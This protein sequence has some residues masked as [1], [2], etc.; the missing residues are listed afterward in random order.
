M[1]LVS[2]GWG[3][4]RGTLG[5]LG[6][7]GSRCLGGSGSPFWVSDP[8]PIASPS[9]SCSDPPSQ[10][11]PRFHQGAGIVR[12][13]VRLSGK[14]GHIDRASFSG[15]LQSPVCH[16]QSHRGLAACHRPV[17]PQRLGGALQFSHEDCPVRSPV[18]PSG[19]LD[20]V[21]GSP[22]RLP[23]GSGTS[24]LSPFPEVLRGGCSVS[25]SS[26]VLRP[27]FSSSGIH[28][29]H[30]SYIFHHASPRFSSSP[31]FG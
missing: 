30:G 24:S 21:P 25:V 6:G 1:S 26:P 5:G 16:S 10:L 15:I 11:Q 19:R 22:E 31:L 27:V 18:S 29:C 8:F 12:C 7:V 3:L 17:T 4:S 28:P 9:L 2:Q 14:E 23:P 20:G 13:G